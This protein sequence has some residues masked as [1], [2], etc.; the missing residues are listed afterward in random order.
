M[1]WTYQLNSSNNYLI[2]DYSFQK[3][4]CRSLIDSLIAV[5]G[6][7]RVSNSWPLRLPVWHTTFLHPNT[8]QAFV[9]FRLRMKSRNSQH[10]LNETNV[11]FKFNYHNIE[12]IL[13]TIPIFYYVTNNMQRENVV[14]IKIDVEFSME[15]FVLR[16]PEPKQ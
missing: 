12:M 3:G 6:L 16:S 14:I 15:I 7:S 2:D 13:N 5:S 9:I 8:I 11:L 1:Y 10:C 4:L